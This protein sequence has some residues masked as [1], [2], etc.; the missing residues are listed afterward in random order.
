MDYHFDPQMAEDAL[1]NGYDRAKR[2]LQDPD[3]LEKLLQQLEQKLKT[4]PVV[5]DKLA[6]V[7][8]MISMVRSYICKEY[9]DVQLPTI[10]AI[11]STL[12]YILTPIDLIPDAIPVIGYLDDLAVIAACWALVGSD[13]EAYILWREEHGNV[14]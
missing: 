13:V 14:Q 6:Y 7:P 8:V 3:Q 9:T 11:V 4:I 5:G 1:R 10:L 12:I 2:L